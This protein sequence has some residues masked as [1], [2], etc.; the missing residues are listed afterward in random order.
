MRGFACLV[1]TPLPVSTDESGKHGSALAS[2]PP[3]QRAIDVGTGTNLYP[4]L[5]ML[6]W[7]EQILLADFSKSNVT[8]LQDQLADNDSSWP[9]S[10]FWRE[11]L[12]A[13]GYSA[14]SSV[15]QRLRE[16]VPASRDTRG[17]SS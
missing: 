9:W 2:R 11:M 15:R 16:A 3:V 4:A 10:S 13:K 14:V 5:L 17:S 8:W 12:K 7:T 1:R 6:P